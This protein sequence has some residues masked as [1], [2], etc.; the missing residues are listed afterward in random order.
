[1]KAKFSASKL[2]FY[3]QNMI[4]DGSFGEDLPKDLIDVTDEE[5][6]QYWKQ[7]APMDFVLGTIEGRPSWVALQAPTHDELVVRADVK[8]NQ[9][10]AA[11]DSEIDWRQDAV[12]GGDAKANE[13]TEL[14]AW[15]KYRVFLMRID[16][17]KA[18][19]IEWPVAP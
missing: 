16:T 3:A 9:L 11:A 12:D 4:D 5:L 17:S 1:M 18:P 14:A 8:K 7:A 10:K 15:R 19:D 2:T 6:A 13:V